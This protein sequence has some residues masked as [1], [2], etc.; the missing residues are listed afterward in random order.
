MYKSLKRLID[1]AVSVIVI[2]ILLPFM[3]PIILILTMTGEKEVFYFQSRVGKNGKIINIFKFATMLKNSEQIGTGIY[4]AKNDIRVLPFGKILRKTKINEIPQVLNILF[5]DIS[6][7]GPRPLIKETFD[8]YSDKGKEIILSVKPGLTG[9]G[10]IVFRNEE[11][12]LSNTDMKIE[13]F[14]KENI[15]PAKEELEM[16]YV[17]NQSMILDLKIILVT[18]WVIVFRNDELPWKVFKDLPKNKLFQND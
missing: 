6:L 7:V 4:T 11:E 10:S 12:L 15:T 9:I 18:A 13:D 3:I 17:A 1:I 8:L 14:Y 16:W 5:G 2:L